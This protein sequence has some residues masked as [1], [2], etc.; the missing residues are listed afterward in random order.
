MGSVSVKELFSFYGQIV[1]GSIMTVARLRDLLPPYE[2]IRYLSWR[3]LNIP[4]SLETKLQAGPRIIL[5]GPPATD[6]NLAYEIFVA[7]CYRI[8]PSLE[9]GLIRRIVDVGGNVG[10]STLYWIG[11]FPGAR[12]LVFEPHPAYAAQIR[13]HIDLNRLGDRIE[14]RVLAAGTS[15]GT[16]YLTDAEVFSTLVNEPGCD[17]FEGIR[18]QHVQDDGIDMPVMRKRIPIRTVDF[19]ASVGS[20]PIDIL[21]I[22]IEGGEHAILNDPRFDVLPVRTVVMEWHD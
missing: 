15:E 2:R 18:R 21:K 19:F 14:L 20:E 11:R 9:V 17:D 12:V 5:R 8:P 4:S 6:L 22:D 13:Q 1:R 10:F 7:E 3:V 16:L